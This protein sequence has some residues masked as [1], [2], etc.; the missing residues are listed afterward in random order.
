MVTGNAD[1]PTSI[2][3]LAEDNATLSLNAHVAFVRPA[4]VATP[5]MSQLH[6]QT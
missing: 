6:A 2:A 5:T 1:G 4:E 3:A